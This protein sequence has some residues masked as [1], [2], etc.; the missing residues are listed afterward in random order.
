MKLI[1]KRHG[2][3]SQFSVLQYIPTICYCHKVQTLAALSKMN[4]RMRKEKELLKKKNLEVSNV[5]KDALFLSYGII[6]PPHILLMLLQNCLITF[7]NHC[8]L[9]VLS[10]KNFQ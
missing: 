2:K 5:N 3:T 7:P 9:D 4:V 6:L 8:L 10:L 1:K